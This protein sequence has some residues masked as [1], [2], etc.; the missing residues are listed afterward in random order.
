MDSRS[1]LLTILGSMGAVLLIVLIVILCTND[2]ILRGD[3]G[4]TPQP[5]PVAQVPDAQSADGTATTPL[6][7][8]L[9][10]GD[11]YGYMNDPTFFDEEH[12]D[13]F[14]AALD[15]S[16]N[17]SLMVTS[18]EKDLR[19]LVL[20]VNGEL[21]TGVPFNIRLVDSS[22]VTTRYRDLD[23]DGIIYAGTLTAGDYDVTLEPVEGYRV[24]LHSTR[25][26][27]K[28]SIEYIPIA[29]IS[30]LIKTEEEINAAIEDTANKDDAIEDSDRTEIVTLQAGGND[31]MAGID[32]SSW[33]GDIDWDKVRESGIEFVIVRAGYRG[34]VTGAIVRDTYFDAN[35]SGALRAG[36]KVGVYFV[37][38]AINE[39]EAVEEASAVMEMCA[40]YDLELPIYLDVEG[41][42]G[43]RGDLID[44]ETRTTVCEAF[45][46]TLENAGQ[47]G[48]VYACRYWLANNI[49]ASRL[50]RYNVWLAEYRSAP[51]YNGYY[52]MWQYTSR[53][54]V[55][56]ISGNVDF[57][58]MYY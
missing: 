19:V 18:V 33:Q 14:I 22:D 37:T 16:G 10:G 47:Q 20:D 52:S 30:V 29:D 41:S 8:H 4:Q 32:V 50:D 34:S 48:G 44:V 28:E 1:R 58:I 25:V 43:G 46:R 36:L 57:D 56:G 42:N 31:H 24:P 53:G 38:Q 54:H 23:Q 2:G 55:D 51:L 40:P 9:I 7:G 5:A 6:G 3:Q 49:D 13:A 12:S 35:V 26:T 15:Q 17:L 21:V 39:T 27:V 11:P 45:C